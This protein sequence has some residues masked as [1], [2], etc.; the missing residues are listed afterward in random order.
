MRDT[1]SYACFCVLPAC[2][3]GAV[4]SRIG[5]GKLRCEIAAGVGVLLA[6]W[7]GFVPAAFGTTVTP[8]PT[9]TPG[10]VQVSMTTSSVT[11][12]MQFL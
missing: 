12:V 10:P 2:A 7:F 4:S 8:G 3:G 9:P 6:A 11:P 1:D 5:P